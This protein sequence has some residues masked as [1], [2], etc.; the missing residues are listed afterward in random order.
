VQ[1]G[2]LVGTGQEKS[3]K[4]CTERSV[5]V[6]GCVLLMTSRNTL[7]RHEQDQKLGVCV[8]RLDFVQTVLIAP[9][10]VWLNLAER[11]AFRTV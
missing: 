2:W 8:R 5:T 1:S 10:D 3:R 7:L 4:H 9:A 11:A 6:Q